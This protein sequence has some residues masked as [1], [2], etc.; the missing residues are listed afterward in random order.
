M[1]GERGEGVRWRD[2]DDDGEE[3]VRADRRRKKSS[4]P[5]PASLH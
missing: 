5:L 4:L 2:D 3:E 1:M